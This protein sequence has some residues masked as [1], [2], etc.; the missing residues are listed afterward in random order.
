MI[1]HDD[2]ILLNKARTEKTGLQPLQIGAGWSVV[3]NNFMNVNPL[4]LPEDAFEWVHFS[5][6]MAYFI[7]T[8]QEIEIDLG[9]YGGLDKNGWYAVSLHIG[10]KIKDIFSSRNI[11]NITDVINYFLSYPEQ[12]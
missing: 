6:D 7:H 3:W 10:K 4:T 11:D 12:F 9:W 1:I 8:E 5:E 2:S